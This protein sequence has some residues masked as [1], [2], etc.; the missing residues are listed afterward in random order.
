MDA[1]AYM[2]GIGETL[3][4]VEAKVNIVQILISSIE[5]CTAK[6]GGGYGGTRDVQKSIDA[7]ADAE[8]ARDDLLGDID[9][10]TDSVDEFNTILEC[11]YDAK[12][13][14]VINRRYIERRSW[15]RIAKD[16]GISER[17]ALRIHSD[18]LYNIQQSLNR[19][20]Y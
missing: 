9:E 12:E 20:N 13:L 8:Q 18:A 3:G 11:L 19:N 14:A 16:M 2:R 5:S 17:Q 10:L 1:E 7:I 6:L 15:K 4:K